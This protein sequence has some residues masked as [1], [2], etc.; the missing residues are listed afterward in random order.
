MNGAAMLL[1]ILL[2][3]FF[4]VSVAYPY[5]GQERLAALDAQPSAASG[6]SPP[7]QG[8][9]GPQGA[10]GAT[11]PQG[12][13]GDTGS[14][15][16]QGSKGDTGPQGPKGNPGP[17]KTSHLSNF[18]DN[19]STTTTIPANQ[20][21]IFNGTPSV[22]GDSISQVN[23]DTFSLNQTGIYLVNLTVTADKKKKG[24]EITLELEGR[25]VGPEID[26][27]DKNHPINL[28]TVISVT[29]APASLQAVVKVEAI[30]LEAGD[31]SSIVI[32]QLSE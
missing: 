24:G 12:S 27:I 25:P 2:V 29:S 8:P 17:L 1:R 7:S 21:L 16:P 5:G 11:G 26:V 4:L 32:L 28:Q 14:T 19:G 20:P 9:P 18:N 15:G 31:S 3:F 23:A 10:T 13:K 6:R 22:L 30:N